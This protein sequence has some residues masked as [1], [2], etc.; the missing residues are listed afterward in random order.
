MTS[1]PIGQHANTFENLGWPPTTVVRSFEYLTG[2]LSSLTGESLKGIRVGDTISANRYSTESDTSPAVWVLVSEDAALPPG[3]TAGDVT[4]QALGSL[5]VE[6]EKGYFKFEIVGDINVVSLG[7]SASRVNNYAYFKAALDH[8]GVKGGG[9]VTLPEGDRIYSVSCSSAPLDL[10]SHTNFDL[11]GNTLHR[12]D[13]ANR[14]TMGNKNYG[15]EVDAIIT[16]GNGKITGSGANGVTTDQGS[17]ITLYG[18]TGYRIHNLRTNSTT[19][20]GIGLRKGSGT[21]E[22]IRIGNYGRNGISPTSGIIYM[23]DVVVEGVPFT[24][25]DPGKAI[26]AE[27]NNPAEVASFIWDGVIANDVTVVDLVSTV[28]GEKFRM[29]LTCTNCK[30][31]SKLHPFRVKSTVRTIEAEIVVGPSNIIYG[32]ENATG[33][34]IDNVGGVTISASIRPDPSGGSMNNSYALQVL[35]TV[36]GLNYDAD[37]RGYTFE[38]LASST[39]RLNNSEINLQ[40]A[41]RIYLSGS[42]NKISAKS[43]N[44]LDLNGADSVDNVFEVDAGINNVVLSSG[45]LL[46]NQLFGAGIA[47]S[48]AASPKFV[49]QMA[50]VSG[51][52]YL[53]TGIS[54]PS[55][56]AKAT[57]ETPDPAVFVPNADPTDSATVAAAVDALRDTLIAAGFIEPS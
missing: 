37:V 43:L 50:V 5:Y 51:V 41:K 40:S 7:A 18:V 46:D 52:V 8:A 28:P 53:A 14:R 56:W 11:A 42:N 30:M 34:T 47:T 44:R 16:V 20:D 35:G 10:H 38:L 54:S 39:A 2:P 6:N 33:V 17:G 22:N 27:I 23:R 9:L 12:T 31:G 24:G 32:R 19:G 1:I 29:S 49:G 36:D 26:D 15:G 48:I 55:D 21:L 13:T 25:A 57:D 45:A 3:A 4:G